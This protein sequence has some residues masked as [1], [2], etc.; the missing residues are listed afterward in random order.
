MKLDGFTDWARL[1]TIVQIMFAEWRVWPLY[2]NKVHVN[3][4][5]DR[6]KW[7]STREIRAEW[8]RREKDRLKTS[9]LA[10]AATS[11]REFP[12][13]IYNAAMLESL[14]RIGPE[15]RRVRILS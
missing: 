10:H 2:V 11:V 14:P 1:I 7:S 13:R 4:L 12:Q 8:V 3:N 9:S 5:N 15:I 6:C